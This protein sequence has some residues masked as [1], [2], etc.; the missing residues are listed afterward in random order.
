MKWPAPEWLGYSPGR[1]SELYTN[2]VL[3]YYRAPHIFFGFPTQYVDRGWTEST[4]ALP[5]LDYR[6]VRASWGERSGTAVTDGMFMS[7]RDG[8]DFNVWPESFIRPGLR[9]TENWFYGDNYQTWGLLET[10]SHIEGA[11]REL[12]LYS[13]EAVEQAEPVERLRRFSMRIDGFVSIQ[14]RLSGGELLTKPLIFQGGELI[15]NFSTGAAGGIRVEVQDAGGTV[16]PGYALDDCH[17]V[18][19]DDLARVVKWQ[20]GADLSGLAGQ[21]VR[22][23]IQL[24]DADLYS[25]QFR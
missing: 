20:G 1:V 18:W 3:P 4:L 23:R 14:A 8:S 13:Q 2:G 5:Q 11:A 25:M 6:R 9:L 10:E 7:S 24:K 21:P 12:S 16:V 22:L 19:G 15:Q 17:E